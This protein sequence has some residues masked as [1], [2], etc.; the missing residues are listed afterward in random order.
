[1]HVGSGNAYS[2]NKVIINGYMVTL[3]CAYVKEKA[4][5]GNPS[6]YNYVLLCYYA[7]IINYYA[8]NFGLVIISA[9][10]TLT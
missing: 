1:M 3:T 5:K 8:C 4:H 2:H 7:Y 10:I 6:V 9:I